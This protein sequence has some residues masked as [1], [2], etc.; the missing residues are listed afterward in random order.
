M[1]EVA[2]HT[3]IIIKK[4]YLTKHVQFNPKISTY[5]LPRVSTDP[6][7]CVKDLPHQSV[8]S[9]VASSI[10]SLP[11]LDVKWRCVTCLKSDEIIVVWSFI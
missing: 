5:S 4:I 9:L 3:S 2:S 10:N 6:C 8:H 11:E 1:V 7:G